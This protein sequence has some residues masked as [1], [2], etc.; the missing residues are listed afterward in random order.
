MKDFNKLNLI[1]TAKEIFKFSLPLI[2]VPLCNSFSIFISM[3]FI[4][5]ID[6]KNIAAGAII[7][8]IQISLSVAARS[9]IIPIAFFIPRSLSN[10]ACN[11]HVG[12]IMRGGFILST[13]IGL[14]L[15]CIFLAMK[16]ILT[17]F[18]QPLYIV[19]IAA[20]YFKALALGALP[21]MWSACLTQFFVGILKPRIACF[22]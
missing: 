20:P 11:N 6:Y 12:V 21:M 5:N 16:F 10:N 17:F 1:F 3:L 9:F 7:S 8:S 15:G 22:V 4:A 13:F 19:A 18:N 14:V 2:I